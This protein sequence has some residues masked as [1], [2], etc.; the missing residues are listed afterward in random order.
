MNKQFLI[1]KNKFKILKT[2]KT[3]KKKKQRMMMNLR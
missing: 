3:K 1:F 2:I